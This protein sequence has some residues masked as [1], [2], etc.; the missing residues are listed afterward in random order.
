MTK[1]KAKVKL[2]FPKTA[3]VKY[4]GNEPE[5]PEQP[6]EDRRTGAMLS[7][8]NWYNYHYGKK[9]AKEFA[10]DWVEQNLTAKDAK[11][12]K[13][14][15]EQNFP[16]PIGW[17]CR[18][19][20]VGFELTEEEVTRIKT[21]ILDHITALQQVKKIVE[22]AEDAVPRVTI[23]D[24]LREKALECAGELEG[25]FDDFML[26]GF[27]MSADYKPIVVIRSM[28]ISPQHVGIIADLWKRRLA[29]Y[30][31]VAAGKDAQ[32]VEGYEHLSKL[33]VRNLIKFAETVVN[34][35]GA[36]VQIKKVERKPR[37]VKAISPEKRAAKFKYLLE[38]P[39]LKLKSIHP[40]KLVDASEAWLYE[41]KKR[42]LIH[43]VADPHVGTFTVKS[44]SI[45]GFSTTDT[46][47]K[48]LRKPADTIKELMAAGK[49]QARKVFKE[50]K[51]TETNFNGRGTENL[52]VLKYW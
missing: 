46:T 44:N 45:I 7:A 41:T 51:T 40:S 28:N 22:Q 18:M 32:L 43:V 23:Q 16:L 27:K 31:A 42:K 15:S 1:T 8:F 21:T 13:A 5:W 48:T 4:T 11:S 25:V 36:Y 17:L 39:E 3:D 9:D 19:S 29:E 2:L 20:A 14:V 34:D 35:C 38:F 10:M 47:Q 52:V 24:R 49:P 26:N 6:A 33:Q 37:A 12:F 30:E 50:L